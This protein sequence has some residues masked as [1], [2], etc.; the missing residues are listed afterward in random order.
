MVKIFNFVIGFLIGTVVL[1]IFLVM[2]TTTGE[3]I[4]ELKNRTEKH[5]SNFSSVEIEKDPEFSYGFEGPM[6][7]KS[8]SESGHFYKYELTLE[9]M[10]ISHSSDPQIIVTALFKGQ[11]FKTLTDSGPLVLDLNGNTDVP[12]VNIQTYSTRKPNTKLVETK[13]IEDE[14]PTA[15]V[16]FNDELVLS[17]WNNSACV[18]NHLHSNKQLLLAGLCRED[19]F[20]SHKFKI[21]KLLEKSDVKTI[22]G[23]I[24]FNEDKTGKVLPGETR[25]IY[26]DIKNTGS[27]PWFKEDNVVSFLANVPED[28]YAIMGIEDYIG[29]FGKR[30][31]YSIYGQDIYGEEDPVE[32][33]EKVKPW[34]W[35]T[36]IKIPEA[37]QRIG[38]YLV[39]YCEKPSLSVSD[40]DS[41]VKSISTRP[42]A[43]RSGVYLDETPCT[44]AEK[45]TDLKKSC[46]TSLTTD[47]ACILDVV[48]PFG[49]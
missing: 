32:P 41:F 11:E 19:W 29:I 23:K 33:N 16:M 49:E 10:K 28:N 38:I 48:Y 46:D 36:K 13:L 44:N 27:F 3:K 12:S 42:Q 30:K 22:G 26:Y 5:S 14:R 20:G 4:G 9:N 15:K 21:E 1:I 8:L 39:A 35:A 37:I 24:L 7:I 2:F 17:F 18:Q 31:V 6:M 47:E 45:L 34:N 40:W 25:T 43:F